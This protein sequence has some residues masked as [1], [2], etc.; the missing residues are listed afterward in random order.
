MKH[1]TR[2]V[3]S[4]LSE[5]YIGL[6]VCRFVEGARQ[7]FAEGARQH[8]AEGARQH[9]AEGARQH[10]AENSLIVLSSPY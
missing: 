8:F 2:K 1:E 4:T 9:F 10:F 7:H 6:S 3:F 5:F